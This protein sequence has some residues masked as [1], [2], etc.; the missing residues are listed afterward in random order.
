MSKQKLA[1]DFKPSEL[2]RLEL[3][4][5]EMNYISNRLPFGYSLV[6]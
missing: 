5:D 3:S 6:L 2:F 4:V 1:R